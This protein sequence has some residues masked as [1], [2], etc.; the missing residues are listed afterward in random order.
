M[1]LPGHFTGSKGEAIPRVHGSAN[2]KISCIARDARARVAS[3]VYHQ[4]RVVVPQRLGGGHRRRCR[5]WRTPS[6]PRA[7]RTNE[8]APSRSSPG[9]TARSQDNSWNSAARTTGKRSSLLR[10]LRYWRSGADSGEGRIQGA[11][12]LSL[13]QGAR[14]SANL[15]SRLTRGGDKH[16][17]GATVGTRRAQSARCTRSNSGNRHAW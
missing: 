10:S 3:A 17:A 11:H 8:R 7:S 16:R 15:G 6:G 12:W 9:L 1:Y 14:Y 2:W 13:G 5:T 4:S